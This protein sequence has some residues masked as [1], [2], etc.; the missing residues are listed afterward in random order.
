MFVLSKDDMDVDK[1]LPDI[2]KV[3]D[4]QQELLARS[5]GEGHRV[6][7]GVTGWARR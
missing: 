7:H 6:I 4:K 3:M 5:L 1:L 2:V